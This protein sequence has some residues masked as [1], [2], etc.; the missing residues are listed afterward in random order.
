MESETYTL[1]EQIVD[2]IGIAL[3]I[4]LGYVCYILAWAVLS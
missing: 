1:K 4:P 2:A 3:L